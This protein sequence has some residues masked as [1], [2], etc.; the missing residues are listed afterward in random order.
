[1]H[2]NKKMPGELAVF[3][4]AKDLIVYTLKI[5]M[6]NGVD[7]LGFHTYLTETGKVIRK[8]RSDS[9]KRMKRKLKKF[10]ELYIA[11]KISKEEIDRSFKSWVAHA[12]HGDCYRLIQDMYMLYNKIFEGDGKVGTTNNKSAGRGKN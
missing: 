6:R 5:T 12:S 1:M 7:F 10:K 9:K 2:Y 8:V 11:D 4:K 3:A